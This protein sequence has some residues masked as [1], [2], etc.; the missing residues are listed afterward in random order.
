MNKVK[1]FQTAWVH[2]WTIVK[3]GDFALSNSVIIVVFLSV[4][5]SMAVN[6]RHYF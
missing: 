6:K 1:D 5:I 3:N 2:D 4:V